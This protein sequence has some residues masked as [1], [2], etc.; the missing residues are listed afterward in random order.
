M[1]RKSTENKIIGKKLV[2]YKEIDS[3]NDEAKRLI[4][5]GLGEGTVVLA[6]TQTKGR[7]KPGS[8]WFSPAREGVYLSVIVKPFKNPE[9]L[10]P[11]TLLGARAVVK[12][13]KMAAGLEAEIKAPNDVLLNNRKMSGI[14]VE[15]MASGHLIIGIGLNLNN[16][17]GSFPDEISRSA[18]SLLIESGKLYS[19]QEFIDAL[20]AELDKQYLAYLSKI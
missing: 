4:K 2:H 3:T 20:M 16:P 13:I 6:D 11:V 17:A 15:R 18:T 14:L 1:T 9:D 12:A 19:H 7:G 5:R 10:G 8:R